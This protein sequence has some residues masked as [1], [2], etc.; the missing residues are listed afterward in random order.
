[1]S[2]LVT[3]YVALAVGYIGGYC[4][5]VG[6]VAMVTIEQFRRDPRGDALDF[7]DRLDEALIPA[8]LRRHIDRKLVAHSDESGFI[9]NSPSGD[10]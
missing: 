10:K 5:A 3:F 1:M 2:V 9:T 4:R 6:R 7:S 8:L